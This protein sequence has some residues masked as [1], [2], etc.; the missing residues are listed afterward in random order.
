MPTGSI[1]LNLDRLA[2]P[3]YRDLL[4]STKFLVYLVLV[5]HIWRSTTLHHQQLH[6]FYAQGYLTC[7]LSRE[8]IAKQLGVSVATVSACIA[9]LARQSLI[10]TDRTGRASVYLLGTLE[11]TGDSVRECY[12]LDTPANA[13]AA[14]LS[15]DLARLRAGDPVPAVVRNPALA[16]ISTSAVEKPQRTSSK[17]GRSRKDHGTTTPPQRLPMPLFELDAI[18]TQ[19]AATDAFVPVDWSPKKQ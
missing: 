4:A 7:A 10:G 15:A 1:L 9:T 3:A 13:R 2:E 5:S 8:E 17:Q 11:F 18:P 16:Q 6:R 12:Y 19:D 14:A